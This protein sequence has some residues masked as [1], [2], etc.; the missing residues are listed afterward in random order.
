MINILAIAIL[1]GLSFGIAYVMYIH[2]KREYEQ[3]KKDIEVYLKKLSEEDKNS[4]M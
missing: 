4:R 3:Y 2:D 1:M